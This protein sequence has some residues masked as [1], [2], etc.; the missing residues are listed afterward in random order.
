MARLKEVAEDFAEAKRLAKQ[1][2]LKASERAWTRV[3]LMAVI[4][5]LV[6][7]SY[8]TYL[9]YLVGE[10]AKSRDEYV[11][12]YGLLREEVRDKKTLDYL[13]LCI[14]AVK[15]GY[16]NREYYC[17]KAVA[18]YKDTF[19]DAPNNGVAE[20]I[21]RSAYG[22]MKVEVANKIRVLALERSAGR[23]PGMDE[24]LKF[25]LSTTGISVALLVGLLAMLSSV[26]TTYRLSTMTSSEQIRGNGTQL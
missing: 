2:A 9:T 5:V 12:N 4:G 18:L 26:L 25:L 3:L 21:K 1:L 14:G 13:E 10:Y 6:M 11:G 23:T 24:T 19:I 20:N 7:G 16:A 17:Q 8:L 15:E 22:L